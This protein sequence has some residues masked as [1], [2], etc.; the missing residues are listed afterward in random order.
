MGE[1]IKLLYKRKK[2]RAINSSTSSSFSIKLTFTTKCS[3]CIVSIKIG[4]RTSQPPQ[5]LGD[6]ISSFV[7]HFLC[8]AF[9]LA[10]AGQWLVTES[11]CPM[12]AKTISPFSPG[13]LTGCWMDTTTGYVQGWEVRSSK[14]VTQ[15]GL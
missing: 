14:C 15:L 2:E 10:P 1:K 8:A 7:L 11:R 6:S 3:V 12:T 13:S 4:Y 5:P 9:V